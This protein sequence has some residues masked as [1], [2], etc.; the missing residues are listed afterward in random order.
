MIRHSILLLEHLTF[1]VSQNFGNFMSHLSV[2][3]A[4][5]V[6]FSKFLMRAHSATVTSEPHCYLT[7]CARCVWTGTHFFMYGEEIAIIM[8]SSNL[9]KNSGQVTRHMELCNSELKCSVFLFWPQILISKIKLGK[10]VVCTI[11]KYTD[12]A[13]EEWRFDSW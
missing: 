11:D 7:L 10:P 5:M 1:W 8:Q 9:A 13:T 12:W 2:L 4:R 3:G 6:I